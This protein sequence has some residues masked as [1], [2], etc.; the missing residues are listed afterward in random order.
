MFSRAIMAAAV[1]TSGSMRP[2]ASSMQ[3]KITAALKPV[4]LDIVDESH[5]H[6]GHAGNP[7]GNPNAETHFKV[8][9]VS[10]EFE[11]K[12][13]VQR[14]QIL[15]RLLDDEIKAGVHALSM[16]TKTPGEAGL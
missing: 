15:Y 11:G 13:L 12:R 3:R 1:E 2:I 6:A 16:D 14:H 4:K 7:S 8:L 5:K 9:V 10:D